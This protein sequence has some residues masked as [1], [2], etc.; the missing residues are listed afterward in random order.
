LLATIPHELH[1][2]GLLMSEA[3]FVL[4]GARCISLGVH[5]PISEIA[6]AAKAQAADIVALSFSVSVRPAHVLT[7][8]ED[9]R[10]ELPPSVEIWVGGRCAV[11]KRRTP[12]LVKRLDLHDIPAALADWRRRQLP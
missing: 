2:L 1:G 4:E 5:T 3:I 11:L 6:Q 12:E 10:A 8:L 9:L 7:A